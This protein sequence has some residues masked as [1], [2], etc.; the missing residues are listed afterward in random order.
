M[1]EKASTTK[2]EHLIML[3]V[4]ALAFY[5][6]FIPHA[7]YPYPVHLDE[8]THLACAS[9]IIEQQTVSGLID[10]FSG[11]G[12]IWNQS[13]EVSFHVLWAVF[14]QISGLP[15]LDIFRYFPGIIFIF[16]VLSVYVLG[17]R[18]G[19]GWQ[20][21]FLTCLIPTT[22]GALGPGFLVPVALGMLF[23]PLSLFIVFNFRSP[24]AYLMLFIFMCFLATLH[25]ATAIGL[26]LVLAP[27]IIFS[28]KKDF[29]HSL[30]ISLALVTPFLLALA[31]VP[32]MGNLILQTGT[33]LSE[34]QSLK[35]WVDYLAIIEEYGYLIMALC[36][37]G[38]FLLAFR[39]GAA[40]YGL[41]GGL[42]VL[43]CMQ[44]VY[45]RFHYGVSILYERSFIYI[46][47]MIGI[48]G[49]AG[50][51]ALRDI[52]WRQWFGERFRDSRLTRHTGR[53]LCAALAGLSLFLYLPE[54]LSTPYYR[55]IDEQDY[56]AFVWIRDNVDESYG[57]AILDPWKAT[58]FTAITGRQIYSRIIGYSTGRDK[59]AYAFLEDGCLDTGFMRQN[60]ISIVYSRLE[61]ANSELVEVYDNV[62]L[63]TSP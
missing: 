34:P 57:R 1:Q 12:P 41:I 14:H 25:A 6:A 7:S 17:R 55:M 16:T 19:F 10:P 62:W 20:A 63:L 61:C 9:Q 18:H 44:L 31:A 60:G 32:W 8:W 53:I 27:Y 36:L 40:N 21:A 23:I 42:L 37:A 51:A 11:S 15:W 45:Y 38:T 52:P 26:I 56:E 28:L 58:A 3:P 46:M 30:G 48:I 50:L 33:A 29:R 22:A 54:R 2:L 5:I 35:P 43:L 4:M 13:V 49:G 24:W 59:Q 47:I 39:G